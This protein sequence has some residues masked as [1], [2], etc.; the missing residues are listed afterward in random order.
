MEM[1]FLKKLLPSKKSEGRPEGS[2]S[3]DYA[4]L[5]KNLMLCEA[6]SVNLKASICRQIVA[7]KDAEHG[8]ALSVGLLELMHRGTLF[9]ATYA[10]AA[11][12]NLSQ[13]KEEVKNFLVYRGIATICLQQLQSKDDDLML[14]TLMLLVH[15][16]K[17]ANHRQSMNEANLV[18][19]LYEILMA[20]YGQLQ[21]KRRILTE[22]CSV[23]GQ[24]CNDEETRKRICADYS[25]SIHCLLNMFETAQEMSADGKSKRVNGKDLPSIATKILSKVMF[26]LK[27]LCANDPTNKET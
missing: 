9:L 1:G 16:T 13:A 24:M 4:H 21:F 27:Q 25:N 3:V 15:L 19:Q 14:Y 23:L 26:A 12:V 2:M 6:S 5:L 11:L 10:C 20:S 18:P 8:C 22:L 7:E 17:Y